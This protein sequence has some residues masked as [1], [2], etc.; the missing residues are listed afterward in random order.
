MNETKSWFFETMNIIDRP[1]ARL[2]KKTREKIQI[3]SIR[4][5]MRDITA[6]TTEIQTIVQGHY[7]YFYAHKLEILE[8]IDKFLEI[9]NCPRLS[10]EDIDL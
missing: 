10:Q 4:N 5:E 9:C 3:S 8:E 2:N 6:D 7:E 1:L